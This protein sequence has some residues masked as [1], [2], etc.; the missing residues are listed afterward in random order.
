MIPDKFHDLPVHALAVHGAVVLVP[1]SA[2]L[3]VLFVIP[4]TRGWAALPLPIVAVAA[5]LNVFVA[6]TSGFNLRDDLAA[7]NPQINELIS[8]HEQKGN[9]LFYLM[10]VFAIIAVVVY[11]LYRRGDSFTGTLEYVA[12][13]ALIV[14]AV[15]VAFQT[16][17]VGEAGAKAV[18]GGTVSIPIFHLV[19]LLP[20]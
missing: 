20:R 4:R 1:L 10:I 19:G 8:D 9:W 18:W 13:A 5:L 3:A 2:L 15:V 14:G 16:Y 7:V 6:R 11:V 12:C 17:R